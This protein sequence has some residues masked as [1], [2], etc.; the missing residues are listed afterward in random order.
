M[1]EI[2]KK[3]EVEEDEEKKRQMKENHIGKNQKNKE[4]ME[5]MIKKR[6]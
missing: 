2:E 5:N 3:I 6:R 4:R 1:S